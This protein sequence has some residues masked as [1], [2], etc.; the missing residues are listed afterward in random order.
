MTRKAKLSL[1]THAQEL[2]NPHLTHSKTSDSGGNSLKLVDDSYVAPYLEG[3][4]PRQVRAIDAMM[5]H[6]T[7]ESAAKDAGVSSRSIRRWMKDSKF[8]QA[9]AQSMSQSHRLFSARLSAIGEQSLDTIQS[10]LSDSSIS[11]SVRARVALGVMS[12]RLEAAKLASIDVRLSL[13]TELNDL[14]I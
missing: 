4:N 8:A 3:L 12:A 6:T 1:R 10:I 13:L 9:L 11:P 14:D 2:P 7:L 5:L